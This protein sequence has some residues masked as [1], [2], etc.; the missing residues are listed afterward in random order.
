MLAREVAEATAEREPTDPHRRRVAET[1]C[2]AVRRRRGRHLARSE[3]ACRAHG[4]TGGVELEP[5][6]SGEIEDDPTLARAVAG[7]A[8]AATA[9]GELEAG[10]PGERDDQ[11]NVVSVDRPHDGCGA[12]VDRRQED[13]PRRVVADIVGAEN[14]PGQVGPELGDRETGLLYRVHQGLLRRVASVLDTVAERHG[15]GGTAP[16]L[17]RVRLSELRRQQR[18]K[19]CLHP[20]GAGHT[21]RRPWSRGARTRPAFR[22]IDPD[23]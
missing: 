11:G 4:S 7:I 6:E 2:E 1:D 17:S 23:P 3:A 9:D 5:G 18:S 14:G 22:P 13:A 21:V 15:P 16:R 10:L 20:A 8:V 19:R 12:A